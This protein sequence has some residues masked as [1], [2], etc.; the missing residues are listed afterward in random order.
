MAVKKIKHAIYNGQTY[1]SIPSRLLDNGFDPGAFRPFAVGQGRNR[2]SYMSVCN[3]QFDPKRNA[4]GRS[5]VRIGNT[6]GILTQLEWKIIDRAIRRAA[7]P[8]LKA[9][10]DL[11]AANSLT[12]PN[13]MGKTMLETTMMGDITGAQINMDGLTVV[14]Q[15]RIHFDTDGV[16]LPIISKNF[17]ISLRQ[18]MISRNG[19]VPLDTTLA[20]MAGR[21]VAEEVE[22]LTIGFGDG[23]AFGGKAVYGYKNFPGRQT[24]EVGLPTD[25]T[26]KPKTLVGEIIEMIVMMQNQGFYGPYQIYFGRGWTKWMEEDYSDVK[27]T[28]TLRQRVQAITGVSGMDTLDYLDEYDIIM[29]QMTEDVA[30]AII[31]M[32]IT[33]LQWEQ[34][35]G[36]E[37]KLKVM[38]IMLPHLQGDFYGDCGIIQATAVSGVDT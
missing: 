25:S 4:Y 35:G 22:K 38:A 18:L 29:V 30:R 21:K 17:S 31:G 13:G 32:D 24:K 9:F 19:S 6:E 16:P 1:G 14:D 34:E 3:G 33:T 28:N 20:T 23:Y 11:R 2:K 8:R 26:W 10:A 12:I 36:L 37:L 27:G 7:Q 5:N 15:D